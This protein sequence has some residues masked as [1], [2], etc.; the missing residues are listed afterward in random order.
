MSFES[1]YANAQGRVDHWSALVE[2]AR[3]VGADEAA[4]ALEVH[5]AAGRECLEAYGALAAAHDEVLKER[6]AAQKAADAANAR[7]QAGHAS[8][9]E[10]ADASSKVRMLEARLNEARIAVP[11]HLALGVMQR[12]KTAL[13]GFRAAE[14]AIDSMAGAC[15]SGHGHEFIAARRGL[16]DH[17]AAAW[18]PVV[19]PRTLKA[20]PKLEAHRTTAYDLKHFRKVLAYRAERRAGLAAP[21]PNETFARDD[22]PAPPTGPRI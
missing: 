14:E 18:E 3:A 15:L 13:R 2:D 5:I 16:D 20:Y 22:K 7:F 4:D 12:D 8:Y 11:N 9:A 10:H 1:E 17:E 6:D 19:I 21:P